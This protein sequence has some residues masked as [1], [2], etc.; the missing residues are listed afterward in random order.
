MC[1]FASDTRRG[2]DRLQPT[3]TLDLAYTVPASH[4]RGGD[5]WLAGTVYE[6]QGSASRATIT[7]PHARRIETQIGAFELKTLRLEA[8]GRIREVDLLEG[9][10]TPATV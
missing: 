3:G 10:R 2:C 7:L 8:D 6:T 1:Q 4:Q 9:P 5:C